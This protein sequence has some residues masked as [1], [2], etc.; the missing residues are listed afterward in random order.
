MDKMVREYAREAVRVFKEA[1]DEAIEEINDPLDPPEVLQAP[2]GESN[3][4]HSADG[5]PIRIAPFWAFRPETQEE[6]DRLERALS[7]AREWLDGN[8]DKCADC[9]RRTPIEVCRCATCEEKG[10]K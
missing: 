4:T 9:G 2:P 7:Q 10:K 3:W 1:F 6:V 8:T 5:Q